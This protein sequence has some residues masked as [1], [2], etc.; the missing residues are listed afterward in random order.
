[1]EGTRG[2]RRRSQSR[3]EPRLKEYNGVAD[4][5]L[6]R[7]QFLYYAGKRGWSD[8]QKGDR[9]AGLLTDKALEVLRYLQPDQMSN[10]AALDDALTRRF[11][12]TTDANAFRAKLKGLKQLPRHTLA[13]YATVVEDTVRGAYSDV[14]GYPE[15][16]LQRAMVQTF[17]DGMTDTTM[18]LLLTR[19][20]HGTLNAVLASARVQPSQM[21]DRAARHGRVGEANVSAAEVDVGSEWADNR[22]LQYGAMAAAVSSVTDTVAQ[23]KAQQ[24][25]WVRNQTDARRQAEAEARLQ[26][27][28][29]AQQAQALAQAQ[30]EAQHARALAQAQA[31]AHAPPSPPR[32]RSDDG[33]EQKKLDLMVKAINTMTG[34][35]SKLG[36]QQ[37][38]LI[39][40]QA[41]PGPSSS[42]APATAA[43]ANSHPEWW[44]TA[45]CKYCKQKG[46]VV[47]IC[48]KAKRAK[49]KADAAARGSAATGKPE[50]Q[51]KQEKN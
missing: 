47:K 49:A 25:Q 14:P 6:Y 48:E 50:S 45:I 3:G 41:S 44:N 46:H 29:Q 16:L 20:H 36:E 4:Y 38:S 1:M 32:S 8:H 7:R 17:V 27:Q 13:T 9:L 31:Q 43:A 37:K 23:L 10:F 12:Q 33:Q 18:A 42:Q 51:V 22:A 35:V 19:E 21:L 5:S 40:P 15:H 26:A 39:Q 24:E 2:S 11:G 30:V 28:A 34:V